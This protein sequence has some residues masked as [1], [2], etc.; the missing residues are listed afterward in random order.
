MNWIDFVHLKKSIK[1]RQTVAVA[2]NRWGMVD[3]LIH[4]LMNK[5]MNEV[6]IYKFYLFLGRWY[7]QNIF[8]PG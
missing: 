4:E 5:R 7:I 8:I 6:L 2:F 1:E 3:A